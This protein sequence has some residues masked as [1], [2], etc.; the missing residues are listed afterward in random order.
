VTVNE[1]TEQE[2]FNF[3]ERVSI[4]RLGCSHE[5][6]PYIVQ[7]GLAY[8][9]NCLYS[10][11]TLGQKV[12]WMRANP[13]VCVSV[14]EIT[15]ESIWTS[16]IANGIYQEL[17]EPRYTDEREAAKELLA[18]RF[19]WWANPFAERQAKTSHQLIDPIYFRIN[20]SSVSGL[21]AKAEG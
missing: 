13:K 18:K 19:H 2:C 9:S 21:R 1:L 6:Q 17:V 4:G 12:E 14:D 8:Q 20:I 7:V 10:L 3:L 11:S 15:S 5:D 16:V